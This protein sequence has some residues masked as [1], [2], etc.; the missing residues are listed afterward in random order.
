[1]EERCL[2]FATCLCGL[3]EET[4]CAALSSPGRSQTAPDSAA[5]DQV[6]DRQALTS[7]HLGTVV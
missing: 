7:K 6:P 5:L 2:L 3:C 4:P 1:M